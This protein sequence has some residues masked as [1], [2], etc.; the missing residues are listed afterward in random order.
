MKIS[1]DLIFLIFELLSES[2]LHL[3]VSLVRSA[4]WL[5]EFWFETFSS[6]KIWTFLTLY[7]LFLLSIHQSLPWFD[8]FLTWSF[9]LL[10]FW[11]YSRNHTCSVGKKRC[12]RLSLVSNTRCHFLNPVNKKRFCLKTTCQQ[13]HLCGARYALFQTLYFD[14]LCVFGLL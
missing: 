4:I 5:S 12:H 8:Q 9:I 1:V 2:R 10:V 7:A 14:F 11:I 6:V 3:Q 13:L